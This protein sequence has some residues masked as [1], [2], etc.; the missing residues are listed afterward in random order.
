MIDITIEGNPQPQARHRMAF[1]KGKAHAYDA[2][3]SK[4]KKREVAICAKAYM[5]K[6]KI[7]MITE[8]FQME[9]MFGIEIPPSW[10]KTKQLAARRGLIKPTSKH[11]GD[12]DNLE[13]LV[14]DALNGICYTDD[15]AS[16]DCVRKKIYT[17]T[18]TPFIRFVIR[19]YKEEITALSILSEPHKKNLTTFFFL[20]TMTLTA[21][22]SILKCHVEFALREEF[23]H[24]N[25]EWLIS[26]AKKWTKD[27]G[28][29]LKDEVGLIE[30]IKDL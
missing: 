29:E 6:N 7:P 19:D 16:C 22:E 4:I 9:L 20:C 28:L 5:L 27:K 18:D 13:K 11:T 25:K 21:P 8:A 12:D 1:G 15:S 17:H 14:K 24:Y 10:S 26:E 2:P 23:K 3:R 30:V